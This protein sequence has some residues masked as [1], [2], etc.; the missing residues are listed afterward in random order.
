MSRK[1]L[2]KRKEYRKMSMEVGRG[3]P[4]NCNFCSKMFTNIRRRS[5][6]KIFEE[7]KYL[8]ESYG[9]N[10]FGFQDELLFINKKY[11][12]EFCKTI[13]PLG[14]NWY[15]NARVDTVNREMIELV[16]K[17]GCLSVSYG[18]E[19]GSEKILKKMNKQTDP[20]MIKE[21]LHMTTDVGMP[22][23]MGLILGYP[24]ENQDTVNDTIQLL[25]EV[26]YPG[27][28]FRYITPY[29]GSQLYDDCLKQKIITNEE[30]YLESLG[31]G[32]GPYR[33]RINFS[34]LSDDELRDLAPATTKKVF[35]NYLRYLLLHPIRLFKYLRY[36]DFMNPMYFLYNRWQHPTN[37][38]KAGEKK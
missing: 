15:G 14:I 27:L 10:I 25:K 8:K 30:Q 29:P 31:D 36:K 3:C 24:G 33:F 5:I 38:D 4:F 12:S 13:K 18:I 1:F 28:S 9:I 20:I 35:R 7:I 23:N 6:K 2:I 21:T 19:S 16:A 17:N 11:I 37:Y 34:D 26:G 32:T 22:M